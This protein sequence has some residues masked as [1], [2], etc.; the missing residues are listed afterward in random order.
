MAY[1]Y[2]RAAPATRIL[3]VTGKVRSDGIID[4]DKNVA[5]DKNL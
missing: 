5:N 2:C 1:L 4:S 3:I